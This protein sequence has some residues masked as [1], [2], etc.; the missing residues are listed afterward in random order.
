MHPPLGLPDE[1]RASLLHMLGKGF[2]WL[3]WG[4][5]PILGGPIVAGEVSDT[6]D[7]VEVEHLA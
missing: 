5:L 1:K 6:M 7:S 4:H 2:N 3:S